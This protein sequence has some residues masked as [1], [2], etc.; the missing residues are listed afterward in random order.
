MRNKRK[1]NVQ[2]LILAVFMIIAMWIALFFLPDMYFK[3]TGRNPFPPEPEQIIEPAVLSKEI[4]ELAEEAEREEKSV[5]AKNAL[6]EPLYK[7]MTMEV[8]AYAPLDNKSGMCADEN[9]NVTS[10]GTKPDMG[11]IAVNPSVVPY[12]AKMY[13]PSYG[14]GIACDTGQIIRE[15]RNQ[16]EIYMPTYEDAIE[17]GRKKDVVVFVEVVGEE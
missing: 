2:S 15:N 6:T 10:T 5:S 11:T 3:H 16:I 9:P 14:W 17:W 12:G 8:A 7:V 1:E 13:I 4:L